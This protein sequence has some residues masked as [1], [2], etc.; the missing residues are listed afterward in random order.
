[1]HAVMGVRDGQ[2]NDKASQDYIVRSFLNKKEEKNLKLEEKRKEGSKGESKVEEEKPR[3][4]NGKNRN[5]EG[6]MWEVRDFPNSV[7]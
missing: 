7:S 2:F 3:K 1:M 4:E 5:R 6:E